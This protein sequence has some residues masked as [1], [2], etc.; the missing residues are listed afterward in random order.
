M[1]NLSLIQSNE[2]IYGF[3]YNSTEIF[4]Q[5]IAK[6]NTDADVLDIIFADSTEV[7][8]TDAAYQNDTEYYIS[9]AQY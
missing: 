1:N 4:N 2:Q 6:S 8:Y 9:V 3:I 7:V 5:A